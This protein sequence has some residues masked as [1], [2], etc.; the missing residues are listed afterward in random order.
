MTR[1]VQTTLAI[2]RGVRASYGYLLV[3]VFILLNLFGVFQIAVDQI[4]IEVLL[5]AAG[6]SV[7]FA[8]RLQAR[9]Q[10][11]RRRSNTSRLKTG[12]MDFEI[13]L[14]LIVFFHTVLQLF[15]GLDTPFYPVFYLLIALITSY[16]ERRFA[17]ALVLFAISF[18]TAHYLLTETRVA[19]ES[20]A[21]HLAY[22]ATFGLFGQ[23]LTRVEISRLRHRSQKELEQEKKR[24]KDDAQIY[25]LVVTPTESAAYDEDR[26]CR[27]SIEQVH[28]ALYFN[29]ALLKRVM[30]LH[31]CVILMHDDSGEQ[32]HITEVISDSDDIAEGPFRAG[33]GAIGGADTR[34]QVI[35]L[36]H[37]QDGYSGICYYRSPAAVRA[38]L[39]VPLTENGNLGGALC[40]D[41]I[42]DFP[43]SSE[44]QETLQS[45]AEH[46]VRILQNERVFVQLEKSKREQTILYQASKALGA[47]LNEDAVFDAGL[48]AAADI[49]PYEFAAITLYDHES[50]RHCIRRAVGQGAQALAN[51]SF[52]DNTSLTAMAVKNCHYLPYRGQFDGSQQVVYTRKANL[53]GMG[54]LLILPLIVREKAVGTLALATHRRNAFTKT[55]RPA[56]QALANQLAIAL[57]NAALVARLEKQATTDG[58]T[59]CQNKNAFHEELESKLR[60]AERFKRKL[61]LVIADLDH[62]KN[63]NDTYGH[64]TGDVVLRELGR[65]L[66]NMKRETDSV[67]RFG[68]EEFC[69]LCEETD[70]KGA[71]QLAERV[72]EE[73]INTTFQTELGKLKVTCSLGVATYPNHARDRQSLFAA[74]DKALYTAKQRGR[75]CVYSIGM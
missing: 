43:F 36:E 31:S 68:G 60:A 16:S 53:A 34:G 8:M 74:A 70:A 11:K 7:V 72:R 49:V 67:A 15:G 64:A 73:L 25:R 46:I 66:Q 12:W 22:V 2:R 58:L 13:A 48:S 65:I 19:L 5:V 45:A 41:R 6:W 40:A 4:G 51:L 17:W 1:L 23:L 47:A 62:F 69:L 30:R 44:D 18:E 59:G 71:H 26:L 39:A 29:L 24:I 35:N 61:S 3:V 32:L 33:E 54:S 28:H 63:V 56:L 9:L 14:L 52:R 55:I 21:F 27:S 57:S 75:N 42:E 20:F 50:H 38:F 10:M 37:L